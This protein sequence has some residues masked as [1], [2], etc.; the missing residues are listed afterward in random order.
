M[1]AYFEACRSLNGA[2]VETCSQADF[3]QTEDIIRGWMNDG[4]MKVTGYLYDQDGSGSTDHAESSSKWLKHSCKTLELDPEDSITYLRVKSGTFG[5]ETIELMTKK[6]PYWSVSSYNSGSISGTREYAYKNDNWIKTGAE[7]KKEMFGLFGYTDPVSGNL[8]GLGFVEKDTDCI[9]DFK[10]VVGAGY[11]WTSCK[12]CLEPPVRPAE[13]EAEI[14]EL[15][16]QAEQIAD[17]KIADHD[18]DD[19]AEVALVVITVL[20]YVALMAVV[21][22][23]IY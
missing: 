23:L 6:Q 1:Y 13:F 8:N 7:F 21:G 22:V 12:T 20:V 16:A 9:K 3:T 10:D 4:K 19:E 11:N 14:L 15:E 2:D 17:G 5:V 18:H